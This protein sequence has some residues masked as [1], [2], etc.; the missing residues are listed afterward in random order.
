[1]SFF[2]SA[3]SNEANPVVVLP[4][5]AHRFAGG[6]LVGPAIRVG[7]DFCLC[8]GQ[9]IFNDPDLASTARDSGPAAAWQQAFAQHGAMAP[10]HVSGRFAVL[11]VQPAAQRVFMATDRFA[12]WPMCYA[13][14]QGVLHVSHRADTVPLPGR[15]LSMQA[16]FDYLYHHCIPAPRTVFE[17][18]LRLRAGHV[19]RKSVV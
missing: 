13:Q 2:G 11:L 16:L 7:Q 10:S 19:D 6:F 3:S 14:D 18:V 12:T 4:P 15:R 17:G 1:M 5:G 8:Q 9:S